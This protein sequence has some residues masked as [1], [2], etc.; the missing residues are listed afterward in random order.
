MVNGPGRALCRL[1]LDASSTRPV[2]DDRPFWKRMSHPGQDESRR[3]TD[4][5]KFPRR[6]SCIAKEMRFRPG[7]P[8]WGAC[9]PIGSINK[10]TPV[11]VMI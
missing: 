8:L 2:K 10:R 6:G 3:L 1:G 5:P 11:P 4:P 7:V 9:C